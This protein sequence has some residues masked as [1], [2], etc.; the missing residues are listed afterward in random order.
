MLEFFEYL[1]RWVQVVPWLVMVA[2]VI[3]S[4]TDTHKDDAVIKKYYRFIDWLALNIGKAKD[5]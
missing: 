5:K 3:A 2:S 1:I 4:C